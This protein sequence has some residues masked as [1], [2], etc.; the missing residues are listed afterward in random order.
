MDIFWI[1]GFGSY[2]PTIDLAANINHPRV[3][4]CTAF[5]S[6]LMAL[7]APLTKNI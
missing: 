1:F 3:V 6:V 5:L 4:R 7:S 2:P